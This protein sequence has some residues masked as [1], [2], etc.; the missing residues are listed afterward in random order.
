MTTTQMT[1]MAEF[2]LMERGNE[3]MLDYARRQA[4]DAAQDL[5]C[6]LRSRADDIERDATRA[7]AT[8]GKSEHGTS[9]AD[10]WRW[11]V[12]AAGAPI[13][14]SCSLRSLEIAQRDIDRALAV[15]RTL[16]RLAAPED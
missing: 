8:D 16:E 6:Y 7:A 9:E 13:A 10:L 5:V 15:R 2:E 11:I 14:N 12:D 4:A 1:N 3:M